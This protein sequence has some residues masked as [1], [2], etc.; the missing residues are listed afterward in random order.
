MRRLVWLLAF[1]FLLAPGPLSAQG[2]GLFVRTDCTTITAAVAGQTWCFDATARVM[3]VWN[4]STYVSGFLAPGVVGQTLQTQGAGADPTWQTVTSGV[5]GIFNVVDTYGAKGNGQMVADGAMTIGTATLTSASALF[6]S[7]DV[8]KLIAVQ[9]AGAAGAALETSIIGFTNATTITLNANAV[10][11]VTGQQVVWAT[12][13]TVAINNALAAAATGTG[14][15]WLPNG[16]Y[17]TCNGLNATNMLN[18]AVIEG[19]GGRAGPQTANKGVL[20]LPLCSNKVVLDLTG[21]AHVIVRNM[22]IGASTNSP[23]IPTAGILL[24]QITGQ[25]SSTRITLEQVFVSGQWAQGALYNYGVGANLILQSSFYNYRDAAVNTVAFSNDNSPGSVTSAYQTISAAT[26]LD[27][28]DNVWIRSEIHEVGKAAGASLGAAWRIHGCSANQ[29][30]RGIVASANFA[31][32]FGT[33]G[34]ASI[35]FDAVD[36]ASDN[37]TAPTNTFTTSVT[38]T[39]FVCLQC[40]SLSSSPFGGAGTYGTTTNYGLFGTNVASTLT[41]SGSFAT[42]LTVSGTTALTLPTSGTVTA[43]GNTVTGSGSV[44]LATTPTLVTPV[45][46]AATATSVNFGGSSLANYVCCTTWTPAD[47]SGA[48]LTFTSVS[49]NYT[50]VGNM[51]FVHTTLAYPVTVDGSNAVISG[52]PIASPNFAFVR[53]TCTFNTTGATARGILVDQNAS[54][55]SVITATAGAVTNAQMSA[56]TIWFSCGSPAS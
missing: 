46:G 5:P 20:I 45:L 54:T 14:R 4:G 40:T 30:I 15:V 52:L 12:D 50:R 33:S 44:V 23:V 43:Q 22:Q 7:G 19:A 2:P 16:T 37:G 17:G 3:K 36:F 18:G 48:G 29:F 8:G 6:A 25:T 9:G 13:D 53:G 47:G 49:A 24:A 42:T 51:V 38:I 35:F 34:I 1:A 11:T 10:A 27:C 32:V 56:T 55:L 41:I 39:S 28:G 26:N 31:V 21:S